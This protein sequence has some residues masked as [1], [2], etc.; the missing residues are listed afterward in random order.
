[1]TLQERIDI[2]DF[3]AAARGI[4]GVLEQHRPATEAARSVH[5]ASIEALHRSGLS[6]LLAPRRWGGHEAPL[7]AQV[8]T[9]A[10]EAMA[11]PATSWVQM[12]CGAHSFV[13]GGF[14]PACQEEVFG[15]DP[16]VLIAGTLASQGEARRSGGG[17]VVTGRW[18]FCSGVDHSPW[19]LVGAGHREA[20][21][22][23]P[24]NVHVVV[25]TADV[26][27]DDT[28]F[29]LGMRGTGSKDVVLDAVFVPEHRTMST[30]RLFAGRS[31]H[32]GE[33]ATG[34]Y[35]HP[36]LPSLATQLAGSILGMA[37]RMVE[38]F[39]ERTRVRPDVYTG[40]QKA[41][42][43]A[44]QRRLA[45]AMAEITSAE[46]LVERSC[47]TFDELS[48]TRQP[49]DVELRARLRW[50]A[51][52]AV[53]LCR[54]AAERLFVGSGAHAAYDDSPLQQAYRDIA[55][56]TRH[57]AVDV[58]GAAEVQGRL[59]LGLDPGSPLA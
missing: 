44:L 12:V 18:Q 41:H 31:P 1:V 2:E 40:G 30:G 8:R 24:A 36:V 20:G 35:V 46:L 27:V 55:M 14:P 59:A 26:E 13:L 47:D 56:A 16:G 29:T 21:P 22:E 48:A 49:A 45:E 32:G 52:Y 50:Q 6:R 5:P 58:D 17:W 51:A 9:C 43:A 11:C 33:Q 19:L 42:S 3:V 38:L 7:R 34:L 37:Q 54:R 25:P 10:V 4:A 53:E 28:W 23:D 39:V 57:A 15:S